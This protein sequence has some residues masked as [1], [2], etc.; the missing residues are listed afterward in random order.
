VQVL[1]EIKAE[2]RPKGYRAGIVDRLMGLASGFLEPVFMRVL[3]P[4]RSVDAKDVAWM[5]LQ[6]SERLGKEHLYGP[7]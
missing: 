4:W 3:A 1:H 6:V 5:R 7:Q 2:I